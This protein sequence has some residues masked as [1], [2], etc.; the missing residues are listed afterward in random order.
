MDPATLALIATLVQVVLVPVAIGVWKL[1]R[2]RVADE[3]MREFIDDA[4]RAAEELAAAKRLG[5][6]V[7]YAHVFDAIMRQYPDMPAEKIE[8]KINA[9]V[10]AAGLGA[11]AKTVTDAPSPR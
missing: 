1:Y 7:K 5:K 11:S 9:A 2:D 3:R 10:Q 4:V 8:Q 6:Q